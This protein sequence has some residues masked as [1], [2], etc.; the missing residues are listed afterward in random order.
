MSRI[1]IVSA[2]KRPDAPQELCLTKATLRPVSNAPAAVRNGLGSPSTDHALPAPGPA[3]VAAS[4]SVP[5]LEQQM[6]V[7]NDQLIGGTQSA[8]ASIVELSN[9]DFPSMAEAKAAVVS[10]S[11]AK[12]FAV[13]V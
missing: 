3:H 13:A 4:G 9:R 8:P 5:P 10:L 2:P 12:G 1:L 6:R 7:P 11:E